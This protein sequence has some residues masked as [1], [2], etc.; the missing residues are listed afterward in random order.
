M[1]KNNRKRNRKKKNDLNFLTILIAVL[2]VFALIIAYFTW[3]KKAQKQNEILQHEPSI[4]PRII[5][6]NELE[7]ER[8]NIQ[9]KKYLVYQKLCEF[10]VIERWCK[11][12]IERVFKLGRWFLFLGILAG[13]II[14]WIEPHYF[15]GL[16][17]TDFLKGINIIGVLIF[18]LYFASSDTN[19]SLMKCYHNSKPVAVKFFMKLIFWYFKK[20]H[21]IRDENKEDLKKSLNQI[22]W[23]LKSVIDEIRELRN[24]LSKENYPL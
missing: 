24:T 6:L 13:F 7:R 21:K 17:A 11:E 1:G 10:N 8:E 23:E 2:A 12:K 5:K 15:L 4:D 18:L 14:S 22:F 3:R 16:T 19:D 20:F 9:F